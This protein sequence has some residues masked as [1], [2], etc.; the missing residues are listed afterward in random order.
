M[1]EIYDYI[2][3]GGGL[4]GCALAGRLSEKNESLRILIIE[5]GPN[6]VDHPLT[7]T[8]L[9][10]FGAHHSPL[11]WD[12]TTVPQKHLNNRECYNG[13][14]KALGGGT[15]I[16][17]GTWTRGNSADYNLWSKL[18]GD[19]S[20][21]YDGLLPYFKR[22]ETHY[23]PN[24]DP[25][26]HGTSGPIHNTIVA[27]TSP[28]RKYPLKEPVRSAWERIGVK[29][30]PD[31][32]AGM[33]LGLADIGE[34]WRKGQRQL[35]SEAYGLSR[36][37]GISI[38][39]DT[40]VAK[41][42]LKEQDGQQ[43]ATG[44]KVVNGHEYHASKEVIISAGTYRTP[45][46]LMLSGI[47]P[48]EELAKHNIPQ[49][50]NA[51]EVG[52]NFHDHFGFLQSWKLRHPEQ[53][54]SMGTPLWESPAYAMGVPY[55]WNVTL[56]TPSDELMRALQA[57]DGQAPEDHPYLDPDFAHSEILVIYA[58]ISQSV[59]EFETPMDGTH[60]STAV[61][62]MA[63]T[64]RGQITLANADPANA[65]VID[66][67]YYSKEVDRA[68]MRDGI[69]KVAK[70]LLDTPEGKGM[71]E[72]EV[73]QPDNGLIKPD[74]TDEEIDRNVRRGGITFFH[75]GGSASMG[76]VVDTQLRVKGVKGLRVADA[77]VLPVPIVAHYQAILYA[78]AEK[79]AD[80]ISI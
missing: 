10:C 11:D 78:V 39:T 21:S 23:D 49:L 37:Q 32:N 66:P 70:L 69:R 60:I 65:P 46:V 79:A 58:P 38:I 9:A 33:P 80:L 53:G 41:V 5:A 61:L 67:N 14:G 15:A 27:L 55:D 31:A 17:Y 18:V 43:V 29:Y 30:N 63:P 12:Y 51:P 54:L 16:N 62:L 8:P 42:I 52:R 75:P 13:A 26:I 47:G 40:L 48:A 50:V 25:A 24:A 2:V 45:Q 71:V 77:S 19:S 72:H 4:T 28:D 36:R 64:A 57:D 6:V 1:S 7:S 73:P 76:K 3:V 22:T 68:I 56:Q 35:A 44:V 34:N 20:W 59:V 74:S